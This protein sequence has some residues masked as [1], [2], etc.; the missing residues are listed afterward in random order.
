MCQS[1]TRKTAYRPWRRIRLLSVPS[2]EPC[3]LG[4]EPA[5]LKCDC[6]AFQGFRRVSGVRVFPET[7]STIVRFRNSMLFC[8]KALHNAH[9]GHIFGDFGTF[10]MNKLTE[11]RRLAVDVVTKGRWIKTQASRF[12]LH[13][14]H[15]SRQ[16]TK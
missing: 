6:S 7:R 12:A 14:D 4:E 16:I 3:C 1:S 9:L 2:K 13:I 5:F 15:F 11:A 10:E 8:P